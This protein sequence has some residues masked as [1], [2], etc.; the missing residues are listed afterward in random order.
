MIIR[1]LRAEDREALHRITIECF[2]DVSMLVTA[3]QLFGRLGGRSWQSRKTAQVDADC[4]R[5]PNGVFVAVEG[6]RV[7]G[8]VTTSLDPE[9]GI[10]HIPNIAVDP[11]CQGKGIGSALLRAAFDYFIAEG[12]THTQ[13]ETLENNAVGQHLYPKA[14]FREIARQIYYMMEIPRPEP[15]EA[16]PPAEDSS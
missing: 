10:G 16:P 4:E 5:N 3:E 13:I 6:E 14:G 9:M 8:F 12:I 15:D 1:L 2:R 7:V 11:S